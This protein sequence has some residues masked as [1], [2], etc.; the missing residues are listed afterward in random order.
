MLQRIGLGSPIQKWTAALGAVVVV[1]VLIGL[2]RPNS[3]N[4]RHPALSASSR[5]TLALLA[6]LPTKQAKGDGDASTWM[7]P[8]K[9]Y[10]CN[11]V[12]RL[13]GVKA[14]Y[15]LWVTPAERDA[16]ARVLAGC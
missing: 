5:A 15:H 11:Y 12:T 16:I 2:V 4:S 10:R 9:A 14:R 7:P 1:L 6:S 3:A 8:D 13:V